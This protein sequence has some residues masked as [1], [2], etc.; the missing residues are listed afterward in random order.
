MP[1]VFVTKVFTLFLA[2]VSADAILLLF[3]KVAPKL[4]EE[5]DETI[6]GLV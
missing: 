1:K 4:P 5:V 2:V 3:V 6:V